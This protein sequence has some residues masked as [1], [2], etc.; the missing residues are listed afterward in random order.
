[1][2][3]YD[4]L[5][6][7]NDIR[8]EEY[9]YKESIPLTSSQFYYRSYCRWALDELENYIWKNKN[10]KNDVLYLLESYRK[11]MDDWSSLPNKDAETCWMFSIAYDIVTDVI[12]QVIVIN[13]AVGEQYDIWVAKME[14]DGKKNVL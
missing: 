7:I 14:E 11:K 12:D 9:S 6:I 5:E 13:Q 2:T 3:S 1:M 10:S 4:V 8:I